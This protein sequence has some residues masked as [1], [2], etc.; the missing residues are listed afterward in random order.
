MKVY[1]EHKK[2]IKLLIT[3]FT[4]PHELETIGLTRGSIIKLI[5]TALMQGDMVII[6]DVA[7]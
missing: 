7:Q 6:D 4:Y 1:L 3:F 5:F 2:K